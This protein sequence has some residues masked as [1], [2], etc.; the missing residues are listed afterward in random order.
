MCIAIVVGIVVV[1]GNR[2]WLGKF[3]LEPFVPMHCFYIICLNLDYYRYYL[4]MEIKK[5]LM[6][7]KKCGGGDKSCNLEGFPFLG[8]DFSATFSCEKNRLN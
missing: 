3:L 6:M 7:M 2:L 5:I 8:F 4:Y 1:V